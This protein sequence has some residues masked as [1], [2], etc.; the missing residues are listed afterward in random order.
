M[1]DVAN[2]D[3]VA[4]LTRAPW[5]GGKSRLF[6]SLQQA[7]DPALLEALLLDTI[8]GATCADAR[9]VLSIAPAAAVHAFSATGVQIMAQP[10][11]DLGARMRGTMA[12]LFDAG[13]R[14]VAL[15]GSD[16]PA[17]TCAPLRASFDALDRDPAG[18]VLGPALDGGYYLIAA[19]SVPPVFDRIP[20]GTPEVLAQTRAAAGAAGLRVTL[21]EPLADVDTVEDLQHLP[22]AAARTIAWARAHHLL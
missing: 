3:V 5:A 14:R 15:I 12:Q 1:V 4:I 8:D 13:A 21:V 17:M 9:L 11:G 6:A 16:L 20:W 10:E 19:G 18:V 7:A 22:P 2:A